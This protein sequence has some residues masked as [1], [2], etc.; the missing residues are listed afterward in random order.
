MQIIDN[1]GV[2]LHVRVDGPKSGPVVM[3]S[4]SLGTDLRVWDPVLP[5]LAPDICAVRY[6]KR[7]H[8]LSDCPAAPYSMDSL[9]SDAE[10]IADKLELREVL[11][12]GL[13]IGGLI[14][15]GLA[16]RRPDMLRGLVLMDTAA[17]IGTP[18]MWQDRI[19]ALCAGG[20]A[21]MVD[22]ILERWFTEDFRAS[23]IGL[24]PWRNM[25][26]RCPVEGYIGCCAAI[27][28]ADFTDT[29]ADLALPVM[30]MVGQADGAT[31][32]DLVQATAALCGASC[33][34]LPGAG[35][36]PGVEQPEL[37]ARLIAEFHRETLNA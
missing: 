24:A 16:A 31:P 5:L 21:S 19:D 6:D 14:G 33:H 20:M 10:T 9:V 29:T 26:L 25:L 13:S 27:A 22:A 3:F 30:A 15:Q 35:H 2:A 12:V 34:V 32:V 17:R 28:G 23:P 37:V 7:G 1:N 4:N 11:F 36:I 8:G 18:D